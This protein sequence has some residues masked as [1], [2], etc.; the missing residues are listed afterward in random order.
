[1]QLETLKAGKGRLALLLVLGAMAAFPAISTD[2]YLPG[3]PQVAHDFGVTV[4]AVQVTLSATFFGL[5]IGMM[6]WGPASDNRGRKRPA[7]LGIGAYILG[8]LLCALAPNLPVLTIAR[9]LQALGGAAAVVVGRAIV[10]DLYDGQVM[11]RTMAGVQSIFLIAPILGPSIGALIL[12]F[13]NWPWLFV[14]LAAFGVLGFFGVTRLP[15]T[16]P[17]AARA[18]HDARGAI[19]QY[20]LIL[21]DKSF[22]FA[23]LQASAASF[24]IFGFVASAPAVFMGEFGLSQSAFGLMF[25]VNAIGLVAATQINRAV[26]KRIPV[27]KA[28]R[29]AVAIQATGALAMWVFGSIWPSLWVVLPLLM[30]TTMSGPSIAG[31]STTLAMA[32]FQNSAAQAS[33]LVG[34]VQSVSS[35]TISAV[36]AFIP[37][38]PLPKM[39]ITMGIVAIAALLVLLAR[40][41]QLANG[42]K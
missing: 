2:L 10:R 20:A 11:A 1:M 32:N 24:M 38:A 12:Q 4:P 29:F 30:V 40:E 42:R 9:F 25:G 17:S 39:L 15:E 23:V 18:K 3:F 33:A 28:L 7:L 22:A 37:I 26:L 19:R 31:N 21:R 41:R 13:G 35:A 16:L 5:G 14:F 34:L 36:L 6:L 27:A 8:S